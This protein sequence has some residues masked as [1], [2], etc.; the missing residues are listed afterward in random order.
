MSSLRRGWARSSAPIGVHAPGELVL[1]GY[2]VVGLLSHGKRI[3][4]YDVHSHERD[5]RC[6]VKILRADRREDPRVRQAVL[7]EG[8]LLRDLS[9]PHLVRGYEVHTEPA[10][11][12]VLETLGGAT[13]AALIDDEP[14]GVRDSAELG[15]QLVSVLGYLHRQGWLHLD[16][17]PANIVVEAGRATLIDLSLVG[18]AGTGRPGAGTRGYVSPEQAVGRGLSPAS[19]VWG[20]AV[21]LVEALTGEMPHGDEA[22]WDSRRRL[23]VLH[24]R[25]PVAPEPLP[26][27][28]AE[29]D[30]LLRRCLARDP[31]DR[32]SLE[33]IRGCLRSLV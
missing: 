10:P 7:L 23:P 22:T 25:A 5:C 32:P 12:M 33:E 13:L 29:Y 19:D 11:A 9:H 28:P 27:L 2:E 6:V 14:I 26:D 18:R 24:R 31:A 8:M 30:A 4:T 17:K 3:D 1:P 20:L 21:T 16:V 15:L